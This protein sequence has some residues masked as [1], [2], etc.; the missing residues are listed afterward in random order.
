MMC[1]FV[2]IMLCTQA[3]FAGD[4]LYQCLMCC[5][6]SSTVRC[7]AC[8]TFCSVLVC[9]APAAAPHFAYSSPLECTLNTPFPALTG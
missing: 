7:A 8:A 2:E 4:P 3:R 9:S 1:A 6:A 5:V